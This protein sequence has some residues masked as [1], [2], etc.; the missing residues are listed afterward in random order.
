MFLNLHFSQRYL[1]TTHMVDIFLMKSCL[2][3]RLMKL[4]SESHPDQG[5]PSASELIEVYSSNRGKIV[6][7]RNNLKLLT[8]F[9]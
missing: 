2:Y 1:K 6:F 5:I 9:C 3:L 7:I 4:S 8:S